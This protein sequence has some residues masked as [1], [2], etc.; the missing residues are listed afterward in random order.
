MQQPPARISPFPPAT[1]GTRRA[2][3]P[4]VISAL[5]LRPSCWSLSVARGL[6][7]LSEAT[8][9]A[10]ACEAGEGS[11]TSE[12][13]AA[14]S[15]PPRPVPPIGPAATPA[16]AQGSLLARSRCRAAP[17]RPH[18]LPEVRHSHGARDCPLP[19]VPGPQHPRHPRTPLP[20]GGPRL[21]VRPPLPG[22][23]PGRPFPAQRAWLSC[24][25][26]SHSPL[27]TPR[28]RAS[29]GG[30]RLDVNSRPRPRDAE[31]RQSSAQ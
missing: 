6:S 3:L 25:E 18:T 23:P 17:P 12:L 28:P 24:Q 1:Q 21:R 13:Q 20:G 10:L 22:H 7:P 26:A 11:R 9:P 15:P 16:A 27:G 19:G 14:L 29:G 30:A 4:S 2:L 31:P 8:A 5:C